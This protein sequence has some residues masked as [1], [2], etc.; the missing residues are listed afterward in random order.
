MKIRRVFRALSRIIHFIYYKPQFGRISFSS[1]IDSPLRINGAE[2]IYLDANVEIHYKSWLGATPST[3]LTPQLIIRKGTIIGDF[4]HIYATH[5]I[6]IEEDVLIANFV[7][8]SD[9]LH[10]FTDINTPIIRQKILQKKTVNIGTGAWIGEHVCIIGASI[11][12]HC[13]IGANSVVTKD[14]P[15]YSIAVGAPAIIIKRYNFDSK[16]WEK[17]DKFGNF[18]SSS[19]Q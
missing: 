13:V 14:I 11:G 19:I 10:S 2:N 12:K 15:D 1:Y 8:I 18:L 7:F 16:Q 4:A 17:T 5:N 3:G 9:N 6:T